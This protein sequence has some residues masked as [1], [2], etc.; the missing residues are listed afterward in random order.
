MLKNDRWQ[1][2]GTNITF[3]AV[4]EYHAYRKS[5]LPVTGLWNREPGKILNGIKLILDD[6]GNHTTTAGILS[7]K[8][9]RAF[10]VCGF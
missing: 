3:R 6:Q 5:A 2:L 7:D 4:P 8:N 10:L 9:G 1:N